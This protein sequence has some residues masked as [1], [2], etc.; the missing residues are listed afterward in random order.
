[1][2]L[3]YIILKLINQLIYLSFAF[4]LIKN[5]NSKKMESDKLYFLFSPPNLIF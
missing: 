5:V 2:Q 1:M 4:L 3:I